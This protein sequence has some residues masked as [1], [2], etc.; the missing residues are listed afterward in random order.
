VQELQRGAKK[1]VLDLDEIHSELLCLR[2]A[3]ANYR[4]AAAGGH[5][6]CIYCTATLGAATASELARR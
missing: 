3:V 6:M 1:H 5:Q 4:V 2:K